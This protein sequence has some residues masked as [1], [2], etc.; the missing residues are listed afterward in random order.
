MFRRLDRV[1]YIRLRRPGRLRPSP[2]RLRP[3][4][5]CVLRP[6]VQSRDSRFFSVR[7]RKY[8]AEVRLDPCARVN[9]VQC[10]PLA[11]RRRERVRSESVRGFRLRVQPARVPVRVLR[12]D[13]L[14]SAMFRVA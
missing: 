7:V 9:V 12:H 1:R 11:K 6:D 10:I 14:A 2:K 4:G 8:L 13:G 5:L 3:Q